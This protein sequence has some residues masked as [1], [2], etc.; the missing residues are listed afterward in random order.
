LGTF[1]R[2]GAFSMQQGKVLTSGEGGAVITDDDELYDLLQQ[3]RADGRRNLPTPPPVGWPELEE[4]GAVQ[5]ANR[6]LSD[7]QAALLLGGLERLEKEN[8]RRETA[9]RA[10][11]DELE[12]RGLARLAVQEPRRTAG[13]APHGGRL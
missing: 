10:L 4:T 5:G 9:G 6:C 8:Q 1:A 3:L 13:S 7:P 11:A 12:G 2:L